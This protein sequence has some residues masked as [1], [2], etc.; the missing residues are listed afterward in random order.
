AGALPAAGAPVY[1]EQ[2]PHG[3]YG[4]VGGSRTRLTGLS[5]DEAEALF[6]SG[7]PGPVRD[8]GLADAVATA[9]LKVLAA[10]PAALGDAAGRAGQRFHLDVPGW[11]GGGDPPPLLRGLAAA[12]WRDEV[13]EL[14]YRKGGTEVRRVA[15]PLGLVLKGGIWYLVAGVDGGHRTYRVDRIAAVRPTGDGFTRDPGFDLPE[16]WAGRAEEF[17]TAMLPGEARVRLS[18]RGLRALRHAVVPYAARRAAEAAGGPDGDGWV[19]TVL[20]VESAEV[21]ADELL[22]LGPEVEVLEPP[23][24]RALLAGAAERTAALYR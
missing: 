16:H 24:L 3:G 10:L 15:E 5:R 12:V 13:V 9:G 17:I 1:A 2:A 4:L 14:G 18:P 8:M 6:L 20:P 19:T 22:R 21:A 23:E 11:F 7:L